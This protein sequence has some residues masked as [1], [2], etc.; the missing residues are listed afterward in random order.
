MD[1]VFDSAKRD[2][3]LQERGL[4]FARAAE[5]F[6]A[7][8]FTQPDQRIDYGEERFVTAGRLDGQ[9]VRHGVD[10]SWQRAPHHQYEESQ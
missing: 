3:T 8:T 4:D 10:L 7:K 2:A 9:I 1:I 6:A 5:V